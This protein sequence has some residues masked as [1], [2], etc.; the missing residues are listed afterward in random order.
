MD[1]SGQE[2]KNRAGEAKRLEPL[3][4]KMPNPNPR[5]IK[6]GEAKQAGSRGEVLSWWR[7]K[8]A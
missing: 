6:A 1:S 2:Q 8:C 5:G 4:G 7:R 3:C